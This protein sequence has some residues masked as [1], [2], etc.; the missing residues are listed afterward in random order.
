M[1]R[2]LLIIFALVGSWMIANSGAS[3]ANLSTLYSFCAPE[4]CTDGGSPISKL[5]ID[6]S[7]NLYGETQTGG[8]YGFGTVFELDRSKRKPVYK[9]LHSFCREGGACPKGQ[10][11]YD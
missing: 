9:V 2:Q 11:P 8:A 7:G 5:L 6:P 1:F 3:A 10:Q 4:G